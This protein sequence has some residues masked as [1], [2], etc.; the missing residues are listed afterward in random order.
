MKIVLLESLAVSDEVLQKYTRDLEQK[1]HTFCAYSRCDD[2]A[3]LCER[4]KDADILLL[5]NM[6][7]KGNV[8][9]QCTHLQFIDVAF[10]GVDMWICRLPR[11]CMWL[12]AMHPA[13]PMS[14]LRN[15]RW[16]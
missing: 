12:S 8:I 10:T 4:A 11:R 16:A 7:L 15:L 13:I 1:G 2:E 6:P 9:R 3:A 5:A 14:L